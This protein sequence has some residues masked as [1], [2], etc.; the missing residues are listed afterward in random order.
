M[1]KLLENSQDYSDTK[2]S[3]KFYS[4]GEA[5]NSNADIGDGNNFKSFSYN[6]KLLTNTVAAGA[7]WI[8]RDTPIAVIL[9]YVCRN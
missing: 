6:A 5:T 3:L 7:D 2:G 8:L 9:K 1:Y 4:K